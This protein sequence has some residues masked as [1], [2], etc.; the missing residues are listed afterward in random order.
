M[1]ICNMTV[2][3]GATAGLIA[4]DA[5]TFAYLRGRP[6]APTGEA[7]ERAVHAWQRLRTSPAASFDRTVELDVCQVVPYVT[8]GTNPGQAV[9]IDGSVPD[10]EELADADAR[11]AA[12]RALEYM[13]VRPGTRMSDLAVDTVFLGSCTNGRIEDLRQAAEVLRGRRIAPTTKMLVVPGSMQVR[14]QA[15]AEG[16]HE[17]FEQAGAQWRTPGC[18]MCVGLNQDRAVA[19]ERIASTSNRNYEGRQGDN[20]RTHL[21]SPAVAAATA[22]AGRLTAP[23]QL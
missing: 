12:R 7:W 21:V 13:A 8:W 15:E 14:R 2:E 20:A 4:P 11:A 18:S 19:G 6:Y 5:T 23:E 9:P 10:P 22:V 3:A 16:L 17:V 1:T